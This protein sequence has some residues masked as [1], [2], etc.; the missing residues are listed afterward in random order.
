VLL[1]KGTLVRG[2]LAREDGVAVGVAAEAPDDLGVLMRVLDE[3][4]EGAARSR[5]RP[6]KEM[7]KS[8]EG[9]SKTGDAP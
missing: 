2:A 7:Q 4:R 9:C 1:E 6:K 5:R 8:I 3:A